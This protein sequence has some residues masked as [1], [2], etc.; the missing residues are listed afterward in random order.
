[1]ADLALADEI[2]FK[3]SSGFGG[4]EGRSWPHP[5]ISSCSYTSSTPGS[6]RRRR[7][8]LLLSGN[9]CANRDSSASGSGQLDRALA[10]LRRQGSRYE[11]PE[12]GGVDHFHAAEVDHHS[13]GLGRKLGNFG[14]QR[15]SF[16]AISDSAFEADHSNVF[17]YSG[18]ETQ[19]QLPLLVLTAQALLFPQCAC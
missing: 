4:G 10:G 6:Q 1:M 11:R 5:E 7:K 12:A 3:T 17:G 2:D 14:G 18:F 16:N 9:R 19:P 13:T 15:G 8:T